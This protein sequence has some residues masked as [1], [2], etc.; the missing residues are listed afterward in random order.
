MMKSLIVYSSKTGNTAMVAKAILEVMPDS[1]ACF[2]VETAPEPDEF[3]CVIVGFWVNK[4]TADAGA[5]H[6][7]AKIRNKQVALFGTLGAYPDSEHGRSSMLNAKALL[8]DS[9]TIL[10]DFMCQ[11]KIDPK[12]LAAFRQ[13]PAD[14]PHAVTPER[15]TR[16]KV[17]STHPDA[18]DLIKA[19][20]VFQQII[21]A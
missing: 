16:H 7:M 12:L 11:G 1:T 13:F 4:G 14:H 20:Q 5:K 17:A 21:P 6:Y 10:G 8:D 18:D 15:L 9:N 19:K 2:P 3:D